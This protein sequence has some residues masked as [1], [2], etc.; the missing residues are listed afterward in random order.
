MSVFL[1]VLMFVGVFYLMAWLGCRPD[2]RDVRRRL[3]DVETR[4][5]A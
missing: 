1:N 2:R 4:R 5:A 3:R